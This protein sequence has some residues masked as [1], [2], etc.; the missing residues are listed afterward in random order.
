MGPMNRLAVYILILMG[1]SQIFIGWYESGHSHAVCL[2]HGQLE[3]LD[4]AKHYRAPT[5]V[6]SLLDS[7]K[8]FEH[9][10]CDLFQIFNKNLP[11]A[12][13]V[14]FYEGNADLILPGLLDH[15]VARYLLKEA[16]K[17]SPPSLALEYI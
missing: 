11:K 1:L 9:Q 3:E 7:E 4:L 14:L 8:E 2:R 10:T 12:S 13:T 6:D 16:P 5:S 15:F 17:T